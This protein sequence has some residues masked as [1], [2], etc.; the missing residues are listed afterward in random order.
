MDR[1]DD[2]EVRAYEAILT[3]VTDMN[4]KTTKIISTIIVA[5]IV[6]S[7]VLGMVIQFI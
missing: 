6:V 3:G 1:S 4:R 2:I 5:L 7:M